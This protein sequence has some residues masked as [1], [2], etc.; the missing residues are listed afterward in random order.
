MT[1]PTRRGKVTDKITKKTK[2]TSVMEKEASQEKKGPPAKGPAKEDKGPRVKPSTIPM[3]RESQV[4]HVSAEPTEDA[5]RQEK[6]KMT[7]RLKKLRLTNTKVKSGRLTSEIESA[8]DKFIDHAKEAGVEGVRKEFNSN[9]TYVPYDYIFE[10]F[11]KNKD[12]N[13][14]PDVVCLDG[15][16]VVLKCDYGNYIAADGDYVNANWIELE[17]VDRKYIAAQGPLPNTIEDFWRMVFQEGVSSIVMMCKF[18]ENGQPKCA[19]YWPMKQGDYKN[20]GKMFINNKKE[21]KGGG[22]KFDTYTLEVLPDG[23]SNSIIVKLI[24]CTSWPDHGVPTSGRM[25]LRMLK[26]VKDAPP[27]PVIVHCSAGIGRTGTILEIET[28]ISRLFKGIQTSAKDVFIELR[29]SRASCIQTQAQYLFI[30]TT[31]LDYIKAKVPSKYASMV[32][33]FYQDLEKL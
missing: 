15:T 14:F 22:E 18:I 26:L 20:Y 5:T 1:G 25:I 29:N 3:N 23:C 11:T 7:H 6:Y 2:D 33:K 30:Y 8:I 21:E 19:E 32:T 27:G 31:V 13:R 28:I 12:K 9:K 4:H 17:H 16:R 24:H 10:A